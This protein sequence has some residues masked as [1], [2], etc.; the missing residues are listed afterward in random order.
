MAK[1]Q[2]LIAFQYDE[3]DE[4]RLQAVAEAARVTKSEVIRRCIAVGLPVV[5]DN[6]IAADKR[7]QRQGD[8]A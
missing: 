2:N 5:V 7:N 6:I 8:S 3:A 4:R 1:R